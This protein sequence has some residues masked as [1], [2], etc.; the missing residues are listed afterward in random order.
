M[1]LPNPCRFSLNGITF[2]VTSVD[3]LFHLRKDEFVKRAMEVESVGPEGVE[4]PVD[5]MAN[6]CRHLLQQRRWVFKYSVIPFFWPISVKASIHNSLHQLIS[7]MRSTSTLHI[8]TFCRFLN[9][10]MSSSCPVDCDSSQRY[11]HFLPSLHKLTLISSDV[12]RNGSV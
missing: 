2:A 6:L 7:H 11:S 1:L 3:V 10:R 12:G 9:D 5:P 8:P 4:I